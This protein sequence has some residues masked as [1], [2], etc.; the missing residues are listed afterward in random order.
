MALWKANWCGGPYA[1]ASVVWLAQTLV[2]SAIMAAT[3]TLIAC[4]PRSIKQSL[5]LLSILA[6]GFPA[7]KQSPDPSPTSTAVIFKGRGVFLEP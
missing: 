4:N 6:L 7:P 1:S 5:P 2:G 3:G